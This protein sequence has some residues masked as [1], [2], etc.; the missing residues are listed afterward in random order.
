MLQSMGLLQGTCD[1]I[2]PTRDRTHVSSIARWICNHWTTKVPR[3]WTLLV[4]L[5][6]CAVEVLKLEL[7]EEG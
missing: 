1:L 3:K 4:Y 2:S 7:N 5:L 6:M